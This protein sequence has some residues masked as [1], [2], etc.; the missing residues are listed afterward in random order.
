M[1]NKIIRMQDSLPVMTSE[2]YTRINVS[3]IQFVE[4]RGR[5]IHIITTANKEYVF[6][7]N[8][9]DIAE[10][11]VGAN[12]YRALKGLIVNFELV[13]SISRVE[14]MFVSGINYGVGRNNMIRIRKA[15]KN[16]VM[17]YAPFGESLIG[18]GLSLAE[19]VE[20]DVD[21]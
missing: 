9:E 13:K 12:F 21:E 3:T 4:Q 2:E 5:K 6:Y 11:L 19:D 7:G 15:Y 20:L 8:L 1:N 16:Y 14:I 10:M 17:G 18:G